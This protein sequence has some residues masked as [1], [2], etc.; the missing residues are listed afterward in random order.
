MINPKE[1]VWALGSI[2]KLLATML[3]VLLF[4]AC[5]DS[6]GAPPESPT[7]PPGL[8]STLPT[9]E[10]PIVGDQLPTTELTTSTP[11]PPLTPVAT[12]S[13]TPSPT[14]TPQPTY[15]PIPNLH[16][17]SDSHPLSHACTHVHATTHLHACTDA[18]TVSD[19]H[20]L[21]YACAHVHATTHLHAC[22]DTETVSD[23]L[24][25]GHALSHL[26]TISK[27]DAALTAVP[28]EGTSQLK[29]AQVIGGLLVIAHQD[30]PAL[31]QP[32]QGAFYHPPAGREGF[33]TPVVQFLLPNSPDMRTVPEGGNGPMTGGIV[34]PFVQAQVL[35]AFRARDYN[36]LQGR[37]QEFR[38]M[39]VGSSH[40]H[41]QG[42][43]CCV[44][45]DA[46]LAPSFAPVGGVG[47]NRAPPKR[48]LPME[49]SADCHSQSTP[50]SSSQPS[51]RAAQM[52]SSTPHPTQ[53]WKVRWMV[54]SSPNSLGK[55]F[56][57]QLLRIRKIM[58]SS[59]LRWSALLRPLA[60]GGSNSSITGSICSHRS[61][62]TS[63]IVGSAF[64]STTIH[65]HP[66]LGTILAT[67]LTH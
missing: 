25:Y 48:A 11:T 46:L 16:T 65:L 4:L 50:P 59:I 14:F 21:P 64:P 30:R 49:Q 12:E 42:P 41:A 44:D 43:A 57:W 33:L 40:R 66:S 8:F 23:G 19:G 53:R 15:T 58:P 63:Q 52:P 27:S 37:S 1:A 36:V 6:P 22:T 18:D 61:S 45:Q 9:T 32:A 56:H 3:A 31:G 38:I 10:P 24:S 17:L 60:L 39:D 47:S 29:Q 13:P 34:I 28:D 2:L 35:H 62:G 67:T 7:P 20:A 51:T 26:V 55:W 5:D 54:L